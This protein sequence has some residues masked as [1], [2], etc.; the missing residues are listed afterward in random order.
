[1][2][3]RI[4]PLLMLMMLPFVLLSGHKYYKTGSYLSFRNELEYHQP[5]ANFGYVP[6]KTCELS[7]LSSVGLAIKFK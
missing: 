4:L 6:E 2:L 1:V 3:K 7:I 5:G